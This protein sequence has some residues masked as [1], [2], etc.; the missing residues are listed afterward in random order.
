MKRSTAIKLGLVTCVLC[1]G[2]VR[3]NDAVQSP[4]VESISDAR[5]EAEPTTEPTTTASTDQAPPETA[6]APTMSSDELSTA[7]SAALEKIQANGGV[8]DQE[9]TQVVLNGL[10]HSDWRTQVRALTVVS[11]GS[12][13]CPTVVREKVETLPLPSGNEEVVGVYKEKALMALQ[14]SSQ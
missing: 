6:N 8:W 10:A 4:P 7:L 13:Q 2:C 12:D 9:S 1:S 14:A 5:Q 3:A 11:G